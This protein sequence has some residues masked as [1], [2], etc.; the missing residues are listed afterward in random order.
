MKT[1]ISWYL[2]EQ[3]SYNTETEDV[4]SEEYVLIEK[5][6]VSPADRGKGAAGRML[7]SALEEIK[8]LHPGL[9]VRIAALPF[10]EGGMDMDNLVGFYERHGFEVVNTDSDAVIMELM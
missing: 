6:F 10:G 7:D 2:D 8:E 1:H 5:I 4:E 9:P 3:E